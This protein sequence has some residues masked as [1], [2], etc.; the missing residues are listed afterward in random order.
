MTASQKISGS[1][2][3]ADLIKMGDDV[4]A[5]GVSYTTINYHARHG[6]IP[7]A[8]RI[9]RYWFV[10]ADGWRCLRLRQCASRPFA[11]APVDS[12]T[13]TLNDLA[14]ATPGPE[15]DALAARVWAWHRAGGPGG[16]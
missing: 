2:P 15:A 5:W 10:P 13:I 14:I 6:N 4:S 3:D 9:K 1:Q 12:P 16:V 11:S 7:G 8:R